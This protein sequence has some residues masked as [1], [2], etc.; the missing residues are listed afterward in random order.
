MFSFHLEL[1]QDDSQLLQNGKKK[2]CFGSAGKLQHSKLQTCCLALTASLPVFFSFFFFCFE[3]L[4][5][6]TM[7]S[8]IQMTSLH[9][10][11]ES[12]QALHEQAPLQAVTC[13]EKWH[14]SLGSL[15]DLPLIW[16]EAKSPAEEQYVSLT[17]QKKRG[18]NGHRVRSCFQ[19]PPWPVGAL[20][21]ACKHPS[22]HPCWSGTQADDVH[23]PRAATGI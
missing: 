22:Q 21:D 14:L 23:Q 18:A 20:G 10:K 17:R 19:R 1:R 3:E 8:W 6:T 2:L 4:R 5:V 11:K 13:N 7:S 16:D 15:G 9:L 12:K